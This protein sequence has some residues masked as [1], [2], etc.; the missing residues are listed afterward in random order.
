MPT[1][2]QCGKNHS[3]GHYH[4]KTRLKDKGF[5]THEKAYQSA[6]RVANRDEKKA[7]GKKA[8]NALEKI[9]SKLPKHE[10][11]GKNTKSGMIEVS[12]KVPPK[13]R[14]EVAFHEKVENKILRKKK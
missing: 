11:E 12:K 10:L 8:F 9:S 6:H 2:S 14:K 4:L 7:F 13:Y 5:P 1:C 3:S